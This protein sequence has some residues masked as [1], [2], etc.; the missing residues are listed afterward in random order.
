MA[1]L[2]RRGLS[3]PSPSPSPSRPSTT[4]L[5]PGPSTAHQQP[6]PLVEPARRAA[7][8][9]ITGQRR[10]GRSPQDLRPASDRVGGAKVRFCGIRLGHYADAI[11]CRAIS[12]SSSTADEVCVHTLCPCLLSLRLTSP[13]RQTNPTCNFA[14]LSKTRATLHST[15]WCRCWVAKVSELW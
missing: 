7:P 9:Y 8:V 12:S 14:A 3:C 11:I 10:F 13:T 1:H 5:P 6:M 15:S 4:S 2:S